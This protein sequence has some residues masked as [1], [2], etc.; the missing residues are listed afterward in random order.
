[1]TD[2]TKDE[3]RM[4]LYDVQE[5]PERY[6]DEQI[7]RLLADEDIRSFFDANVLARMAGTKAHPQLVDIDQAWRHF[8]S[9]HPSAT[10]PTAH[11]WLKAAASVVGI[12][13]ISGMVYAAVTQGWFS[14]H[15]ADAPVVVQTVQRA[16]PAPATLKTQTDDTAPADT[17]KPVVFDNVKLGDILTQMAAYY[18]ARVEYAHPETQ[19]I[20]LY[21]TWDRQKPLQ[22]NIELLN[23]FEHI[24]I[25]YTG[26]TIK[27]E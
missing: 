26:Q 17:L 2:M 8:Q 4:M 16:S 23:A 6:T 13:F 22:Q 7:E 24:H 27:V 21:F 9:H 20:R 12:I 3:K 19:H 18:K 14:S 15:T 10:S 5:H 25:S 11:Y 1:M